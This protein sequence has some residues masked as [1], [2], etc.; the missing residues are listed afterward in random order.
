LAYYTFI[1]FTRADTVVPWTFNITL[2]MLDREFIIVVL[3]LHERTDN[4]EY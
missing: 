4:N 1:E 2:H 3:F